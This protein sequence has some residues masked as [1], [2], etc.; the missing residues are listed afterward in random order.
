METQ[1]LQGQP[2]NLRPSGDEPELVAAV[3]RKDRKATAEFVSR[4]A[5]SLHSYLSRRLAPREDLVGD[6]FQQV[7]LEAW[8]KL[9]SW[10]GRAPLGA[11]LFGIARHKVQDHYRASLRQTQLSEGDP[12]PVTEAYYEEWLDERAANERVWQVLGSLPDSY[13]IVLLWR[14]WEQQSAEE[15][16]RQSGKTVKA[17]ERLLAR[18]RT[19][20]RR[21][22]N[23]EE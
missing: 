17:I 21:R 10:Q 13:R 15:M 6:L 2:E 8:E 14:Y 1:P 19:H 4:H 5:D 12:E 20:F 16:A 11:W 23:R 22:W 7:F 18:A 3:L 9:A